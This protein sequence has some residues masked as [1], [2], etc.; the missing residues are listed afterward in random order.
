MIIKCQGFPLIFKE[1]YLYIN[2]ERE[3]KTIKC[4]WRKFKYNKGG[5]TQHMW[6]AWI[7]GAK[8][9]GKQGIQGC[10]PES[11]DVWRNPMKPQ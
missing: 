10:S 9:F 5:I 8:G 1:N 6:Y 4:T 7:L 11:N 2:P 3:T